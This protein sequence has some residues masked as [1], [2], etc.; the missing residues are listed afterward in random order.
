MLTDAEVVPPNT[1]DSDSPESSTKEGRG[2]LPDWL[3]YSYITPNFTRAVSRSVEYSVNDYSL[4]L[5]ANSLSNDTAAEKYFNRSS[6]W[7][8]QWNDDL[9][10]LGFSG[11]VGPRNAN[12][13]FV[14]Q[15]K[16]AGP[17]E[18]FSGYWGDP[19]Y[20][21]TLWEYSFGVPHDVQGLI[22]KMGGR[23]KFIDRLDTSLNRSL[24]GI[25]NEPSFLTPY[26]VSTLIRQCMKGA[27]FSLR[28]ESQKLTNLFFLSFLSVQLRWQISME[29]GRLCPIYPQ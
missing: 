26:L 11:F 19:A 9:K 18:S 4:A 12:G 1:H 10:A 2:A 24:L 29:N 15:N 16:L 25:G 5:V 6:N 21:A 22:A 13:T 14:A 28:L 7:K 27:D 3:K 20:E 8:N 17:V 23:E